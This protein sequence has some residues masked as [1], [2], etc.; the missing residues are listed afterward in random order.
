MIL[1]FLRLCIGNMFLVTDQVNSFNFFTIGTSDTTR[2][3]QM[4]L[5]II[6]S[7]NSIIV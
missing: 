2:N 5:V 4:E 3:N 7:S 6:V 1:Q